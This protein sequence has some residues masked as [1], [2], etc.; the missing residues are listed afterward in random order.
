MSS[1]FS[2]ARFTT[3]AGVLVAEFLR[4]LIYTGTRIYMHIQRKMGVLVI[5]YYIFVGE[6]RFFKNIKWFD[7]IPV[8][9]QGWLRTVQ[10]S[11]LQ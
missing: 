7:W 1:S 9:G 11:N 6:L 5:S 10:E 2:F 8:Q 3:I 4:F